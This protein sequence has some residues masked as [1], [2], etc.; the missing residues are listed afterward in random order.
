MV[1]LGQTC[2]EDLQ[3]LGTT[4]QYLV[5]AVNWRSEFVLSR[6]VLMQNKS[7]HNCSAAGLDTFGVNSV[8]VPKCHPVCMG[9]KTDAV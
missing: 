4:V 5:A 3:A 7:E 6:F 9:V 2:T 1:A 8:S